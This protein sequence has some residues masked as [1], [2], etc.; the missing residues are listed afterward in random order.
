MIKY[1]DLKAVTTLYRDEIKEAVNR[2]ID[3]GWYLLGEETQRFESDYAKYIGT[4]HC[5]GTGNGLDALTLIFRAYIEMGVMAEGDEIL[6]PANTFIASILAITRNGLKPVFIEP[7]YDTL[8]IDASLIEAHITPRTRALLLVHL[9]GRCAYTDAIGSICRSH[10]L[11]LIEDNAQS[12]GCRFGTHL[13]GSLGDAAGHSF[14]PGKNLGALADAGAVTTNDTQLADTVRCLANYGSARKYIF[15]YKG[16]NSRMDEISAAVLDVK[17]RHLDADNA[18]RQQIADH[19][20]QQIHHPSVILP[21]KMD[22]GNN[23]YHIFPILTP[24]RTKLKD[25]LWNKGIETAIHYPI[26]PH[27]QQSYR[28]YACLHLPI[29]E[30]IH[31][32][33]LSLP[34]NQTMTEGETDTIIQAINSF[35]TEE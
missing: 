7:E 16:I 14:Y 35:T 1:L 15:H 5:I 33:E 17:L 2:V 6:V 28:E 23:I 11:K 8:E 24:K 22:T 9:Y 30:Q 27:L 21:R 29:T 3:S 10:H 19:Y 31:C 13:T 32:E 12:Q 20:Y 34:C 18:R 25:Y 26:P 4:D